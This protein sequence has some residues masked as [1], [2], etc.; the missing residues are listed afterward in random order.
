MSSLSVAIAAQTISD[1]ASRSVF[2]PMQQA[3]EET[4]CDRAVPTVLHQDV[5]HDAMLVN[6]PPQIVQH[7]P[8]AD[9]HLVQMPGVSRLRR[10]RRSR[11]AKSAPN[12]RHQC[13]MLS[14]VTTT[15]RSARISSTSR[16]AEAEDVIQPD[17][18]TDDLRRKPV[19]GIRGALR[20]HAGSLARLP[21]KRQT[22][23]Y[24]NLPMS[25]GALFI[26]PF[27]LT[28]TTWSYY[29]LRG[30]VRHGEGYH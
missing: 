30:K 4:L 10:R 19:P 29:V 21:P 20:V 28:Y 2:R 6:C 1:L 17:R 7:A 13:R 16:K 24:S 8:N 23:S 18:V 15:P 26:I 14:W 25:V 11:L 3:F 27:I 22:R 9:E 12:F 5:Q